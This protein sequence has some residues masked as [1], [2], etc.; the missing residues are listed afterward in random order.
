MVDR[1]LSLNEG[2]I[3][4]PNFGVDSWGWRMYAES[5]YFDAGK[6]LAD[7]SEGEWEQFLRGPETR[8]EIKGLNL[9]YL[10][11]DRESATLS[12]GEAQRVKMVRHLGSSLS[13]VTYVFDEPT[14]GLHPH[15]VQRVNRLLVALRDK[16]NLVL[17]WTA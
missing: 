2:A 14:T 3:T 8:V 10:S 9:K 16:G 13:D 17:R 7:Y 4:L 11:L 15:D 5:G 6:K 12:G 1:S